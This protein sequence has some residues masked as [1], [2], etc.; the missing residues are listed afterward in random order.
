MKELYKKYGNSLSPEVI[1][2][3]ISNGH[4]DLAKTI[5]DAEIIELERIMLFAFL[6]IVHKKETNVDIDDIILYFTIKEN[7]EYCKKL[8]DIKNNIL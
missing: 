3:S 5:G 1:E 6:C 7:Y 2:L 4:Y 8:T